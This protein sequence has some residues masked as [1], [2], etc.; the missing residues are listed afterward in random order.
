MM[1]KKN[2]T[3]NYFI[4]LKN[5]IVKRRNVSKEQKSA[6]LKKVNQVNKHQHVDLLI[7][8]NMKISFIDNFLFI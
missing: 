8:R 1:L 4:F 3:G 5:K 2:L 6:V 7:L